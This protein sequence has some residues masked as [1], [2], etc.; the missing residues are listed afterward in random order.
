MELKFSENY[1][2]KYPRGTKV[3]V[4]RIRYKQE[5]AGRYAVRVTNL[6]KRPQWFAI[7]WFVKGAG[8]MEKM[9]NWQKD[10]SDVPA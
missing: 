4:D 9:T 5:Y 6:S 3:I 1:S 8:D 2:R 10:V 7:E